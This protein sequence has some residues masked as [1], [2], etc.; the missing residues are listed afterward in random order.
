VE[1]SEFEIVCNLELVQI[2]ARIFDCVILECGL[3]NQTHN[4]SIGS[5]HIGQVG[6]SGVLLSRDAGKLIQNVNVVE[7]V[8][9]HLEEFKQE[10]RLVDE[11]CDTLEI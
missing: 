8:E 7:D 2:H 3:I 11:W 9:E 1:V 4:S 10:E 6:L 5:R